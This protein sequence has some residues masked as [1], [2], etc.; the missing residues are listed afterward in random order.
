MSWWGRLACLLLLTCA[1]LAT[2]CGS[3]APAPAASTV[4]LVSIDGWRWDYASKYQAPHLARLA[5]RGVSAPLIPSFPSKTFPN[6]YT[7]VTGL[8]PGHH[9]IVA[10]SIFDP[11]TGRRLTMSNRAEV[12][13]GMWWGGEPIWVAAER[14]G[15]ATAAVFWPGSE[16]P[17]LGVRPRY[18]QP[19]DHQMPGEARVDS[20][21]ELLD[22][23][24]AERPTFSTLYFSDVDT[25]GH[26]SGPDSDAVREAIARVD[27]HL[28][29][30][31][32][33]LEKR[34]MSDR[35]NLV[36]VSDHGMAD[37]T[38]D[39]V[40]VLDD[41]LDAD[42]VDVVD[43]NPTLGL[44]PLPG[45]AEKV[46]RA[47]AG[48]H[49]HLHVYRRAETPPHWR[50]RDHPRV[51][52]IVGVVDE[53][54]QILRRSALDARSAHGR[55]LHVG[56]HGYDPLHAPTMR[57]LFVAAGP[58]FKAGVVVPAFENVHLYNALAQ[59]LGVRPAPNDGDPALAR[60]LLRPA[61]SR[62]QSET[63]RD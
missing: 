16:A 19:Y 47:L 53:G 11:A 35:V 4:I 44:V 60:A 27:A 54:W 34:R 12:Q 48:A 41:Y 45:R 58:A 21:L 32:R 23:P 46:Y 42:D 59:I 43:L 29:R 55:P 62:G 15:Q 6:H 28:G 57:G 13:D 31:L 24:A 17:I 22:R 50:Y 30:L 26:A 39:R 38:P 3:E 61:H 56:V 7:I 49:A 20:I 36:L 14:A 18:W 33:G 37:A 25:A 5:A 2:G 40:V 1:S 51:P 10:N 63:P 8:Y 9:G 52:E